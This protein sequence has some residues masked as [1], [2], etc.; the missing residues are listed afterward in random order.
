MEIIMQNSYIANKSHCVI[1]IAGS[2][3]KPLAEISIIIFACMCFPLVC[4]ADIT[5]HLFLVNTVSTLQIYEA[6]TH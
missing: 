2:D 6:M 1:N 4:Q 3:T 5:Q